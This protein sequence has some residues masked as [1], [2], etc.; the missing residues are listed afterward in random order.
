MHYLHVVIFLF[1]TNLYNFAFSTY[2]YGRLGFFSFCVLAFMFLCLWLLAIMFCSQRGAK[3]VSAHGLYAIIKLYV[4][5]IYILCIICMWSLFCSVRVYVSL[6]FLPS[7][8]EDQ[9][10]FFPCFGFYVY[11]FG[12]QLLF[13]ALCFEFNFS[14]ILQT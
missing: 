12:V 3:K 14:V 13:F 5:S 9:V 7:F 4:I 1:S 2:S 10:F 8:L 6:H 11:V